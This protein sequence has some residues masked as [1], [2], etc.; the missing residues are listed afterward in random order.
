MGLKRWVASWG[1]PTVS[2]RARKIQVWSRITNIHVVYVKE[3][4]VMHFG[5]SF[6]PALEDLKC[7]KSKALLLS[8]KKHLWC[9][10]KSVILGHCGAGQQLEWEYSLEYKL[11]SVIQTGSRAKSVVQIKEVKKRG[12]ARDIY[13]SIKL[14][15]NE[16]LFVCRCFPNII[17]YIPPSYP[18]LLVLF[19][20]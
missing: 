8:E 5:K 4:R 19:F 6:E 9:V 13:F 7:L 17:I 12:D 2:P 3:L 18:L 14:I 11:I 1:L 15:F 10:N 20:V 16:H